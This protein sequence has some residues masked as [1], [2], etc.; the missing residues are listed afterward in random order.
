MMNLGMPNNMQNNFA[1]FQQMMQ[2]QQMQQMQQMQQQQQQQQFYN[3]YLSYCQQ[4]GLN[5][6]DENEY[7]KFCQLYY[8]NMMNNMGNNLGNNMGNN[9]IPN[10]IGGN[11][12]INKNQN[13]IYVHSNNSNNN[14]DPN[15]PKEILPRSEETIYMN[16][17]EL[18]GNNNQ[19][20]IQN[21]FPNFNFGAL[22]NDIINVT[23]ITSAG[24][25][26]VISATK[27]M[28][29]EDLFI[30]YANKV[31]VPLDAIGTQIVFLCNGGKLDPKSKQPISTVFKNSMGNIAVLDQGN[32]VGA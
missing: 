32:I 6:N 14:N 15:Q 12:N 17:N 31:G 9:Q 5:C 27:D 4:N 21:N 19:N 24:Y 13:D 3:A 29:F 7:N 1:F 20:Q 8:N 23:L 25:K 26:V 11:N 2:L 28:T 16:Q 18:K 22:N 30:N 10:N